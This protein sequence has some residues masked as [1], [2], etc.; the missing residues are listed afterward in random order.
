[1]CI[2][3]SYLG[4]GVDSGKLNLNLDYEIAG[5]RIDA[6]N[7]V[8]MDRLELGSAIASDQAV[9]APVKLGLA[10]LR[11]SKGVI[12]VDLPISGDLSDPDFSVGKVVMRAFVNL[13]AKA[14]ASPFSMLGSIAELAGLSGEELG[15]VRFI[16]GSIQLAE[17]E[18]EK[19]AA[20]ADALLDRPDLLLNIRGNVESQAD[21]LALLRD[22]LTA[23][24]EQDLSEEAW[25]EAREAYLAGERS[26]APEA[27]RNLA[28]SRGQSLRN[29]MQQTHGAVSYTHLTLPTNREV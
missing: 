4:Y 13:L 20:L 12:E 23:S 3:D 28:S 18:A 21:G 5:S 26:L 29:I 8:V 2:R 7:L 14:A 1:M 25:Q 11:D 27:L 9:N 24:G 10:L 19:L 17:G 22:E 15:K 6:S 16:P